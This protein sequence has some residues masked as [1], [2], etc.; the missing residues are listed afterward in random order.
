M[1]TFLTFGIC[2]V[3]IVL[4]PIG[5]DGH[6][7]PHMNAINPMMATKYDCNAHTNVDQI[8]LQ[9]LLKKRLNIYTKP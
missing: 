3:I 1:T 9:S 5:M 8:K 7:G 6:H 2:H 4:E